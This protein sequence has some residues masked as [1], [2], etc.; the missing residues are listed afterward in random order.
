MRGSVFVVAW[1]DDAL[2]NCWLCMEIHFL[3]FLSRGL[4][5]F[6]RHPIRFP[7]PDR[8]TTGHYPAVDSERGIDWSRGPQSAAKCKM[9][10][11]RMRNSSV[12]LGNGEWPLTQCRH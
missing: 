10:H 1:G 7:K 8:C 11:G 2:V 12:P 4:L 3:Y 9:R 5:T 6:V